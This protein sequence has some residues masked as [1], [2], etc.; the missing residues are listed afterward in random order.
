LFF[1]VFQKGI[2]NFFAKAISKFLEKKAC[3]FK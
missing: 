3:V 2:Y 1:F